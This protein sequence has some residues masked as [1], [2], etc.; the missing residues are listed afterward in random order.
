[1]EWIVSVR[2]VYQVEGGFVQCV[3]LYTIEELQFSPDRVLMTRGLSQY[4]VLALCNVPAELNV[5]LLANAEN[6]QAI[7]LS[8]VPKDPQVHDFLTH[9]TSVRSPE[10]CSYIQYIYN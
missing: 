4:K 5:H 2:D 9:S 3:C 1:M 8:K 6:P 7:Y 10:S